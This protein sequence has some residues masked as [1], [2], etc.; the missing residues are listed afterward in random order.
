MPLTVTV[1]FDDATYGTLADDG[2][3]GVT[4]SAEGDYPADRLQQLFEVQADT[5]AELTAADGDDP[6]DLTVEDVFRSMADR[7]QGRSWAKLEGENG[8]DP[9]QDDGGGV[10]VGE[11][12]TNA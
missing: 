1:G 5:L 3:G 11:D 4:V 9:A 12:E 2:D 6:D 10:A 7:M 8:D